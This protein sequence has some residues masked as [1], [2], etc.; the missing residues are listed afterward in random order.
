MLPV[1]DYIYMRGGKMST[2][3][4]KHSSAEKKYVKGF[5]NKKGKYVKGFY[6]SKTRKSCS[7]RKGGQRGKGLAKDI[8][9]A[10]AKN[11]G[12]VIPDIMNDISSRTSNEKVKKALNNPIVKKMTTTMSSFLTPPKTITK[13]EKV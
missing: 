7:K 1:N 5:Y 13:E 11:F 9:I 12:K 4:K 2:K 10:T 3:P 6:A 8:A